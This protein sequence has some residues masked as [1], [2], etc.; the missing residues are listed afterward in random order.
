MSGIVNTEPSKGSKVAVTEKS[1]TT[2]VSADKE[3]KVAKSSSTQ[4][5][6]ERDSGTQ[7]VYKGDGEYLKGDR[8][9]AATVRV[10][11]VKSGDVAEVIGRG[12]TNDLILDFVLPKGDKGDQGLK[13]DTGAQGPQG[14]GLQG[15]QGES[16]ASLYTWVKYAPTDDTNLNDMQDNAEGMDYVGLSY[17]NARPESQDPDSNVKSNYSW[18]KIQGT[19][20]NDGEDGPAGPQGPGGENGTSLV[21]IGEWEQPEGSTQLHPN[22][23]D[24]PLDNSSIEGPLKDGYWYL[25]TGTQITYSYYTGWY[26]M[27]ASGEEGPAGP[28][29]SPGG[30]VVW[31]GEMK[32]PPNAPEINWVYQDTDNDYYYI[33]DGYSWAL[34][35]SDGNTTTAGAPGGN[36]VYVYLAFTDKDS[37]D[38]SRPIG[39]GDSGDWFVDPN[40]PYTRDE[41]GNFLKGR[42]KQ[43]SQKHGTDPNDGN[44]NGPIPIT[45]EIRGPVGY[46]GSE[47]IQ[48]AIENWDGVW[49]DQLAG[50]ACTGGAPTEWDIVTLYDVNDPAVQETRRWA[51]NSQLNDW[52][53]LSYAYVFLGDVLVDGTLDGNR[54]NAKTTIIAGYDQEVAGLSGVD[55][56]EIYDDEQAQRSVRIWAGTDFATRDTAPFRVTQDGFASLSAL[57]AIGGEFN[58][59]LIQGNDIIGGLIR[60]SAPEEDEDGNIT[61]HVPRAEL[62]AEGYKF[63]AYDE[64]NN[65]T[66]YVDETGAT[67]MTAGVIDSESLENSAENSNIVLWVGESGGSS[68]GFYNF[69]TANN[70]KTL[71]SSQNYYYFQEEYWIRMDTDESGNR[72]LS[73]DL[74]FIWPETLLE[75]KNNKT[76]STSYPSYPDTSH[77]Y[78]KARIE[79][80]NGWPTIDLLDRHGN[81]LVTVTCQDTYRTHRWRRTGSRCGWQI[82]KNHYSYNDVYCGWRYQGE[83]DYVLSN[84]DR[85]QLENEF[86]GTEFGRVNIGTD[87]GKGGLNWRIRVNEPKVWTSQILGRKHKAAPLEMFQEPRGERNLPWSG[88]LIWE[89]TPKSTVYVEELYTYETTGEHPEDSE[90][91]YLV[92]V[93]P[94]NYSATAAVATSIVYGRIFIPFG[95]QDYSN[96]PYIKDLYHASGTVS[97]HV[98]YAIKGKDAQYPEGAFFVNSS[99][100]KIYRIWRMSG[101]VKNV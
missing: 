55:D 26:R 16:G 60:T 33:Y 34:L 42:I 21:Y 39:D 57:E 83:L 51:H 30:G 68:G 54:F 22:E 74:N 81:V 41:N 46:R 48:V 79:E 37:P 90:S 65:V 98:T 38:P 50:Q 32:D 19:D 23:D 56:G 69:Q 97:H 2:T 36:G 3:T 76:C 87:Q 59:G 86:G 1:Q 58:N 15:I 12:T 31:K 99:Y 94:E 70:D 96:R 89:G 35:T 40:L 85:Q 10:G 64:N 4:V 47:S 62:S 71:S 45:E 14:E 8:G 7:I 11:N 61:G 43:I 28:Q 88:A 84:E 92:E 20:G 75:S 80:A 44:W 53:W 91:S 101:G 25:N 77:A 18:S 78:Q 73:L 5:V 13:G 9:D 49:D 24:M 17:N 66:F 93:L 52:E 100:A 67:R 72:I 27:T 95:V 29:G 63:A 6:V 82:T